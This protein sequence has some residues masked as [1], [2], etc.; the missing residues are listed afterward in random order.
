MCKRFFDFSLPQFADTT[1]SLKSLTLASL[2]NTIEWALADRPIMPACY[3][4]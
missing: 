4:A 3:P 1:E 2:V